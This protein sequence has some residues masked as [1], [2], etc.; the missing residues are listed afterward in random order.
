MEF[1]L[2]ELQMLA[3]SGDVTTLPLM[4]SATLTT[5]IEMSSVHARNIGGVLVGKG[6]LA[7][8][9][10]VIGGHYDH[11][12]YGSRGRGELHP[13]ADDNASGTAA[14]MILARI[15]SQQYQTTD[16]ASLRSVLFLLFD[17]EEL[18]LLG[19]AHFV[20]NPIMDLEQVNAMINLDM[21]GN[22]RNNK[23]SISGS[24]TAE[25]FETLVPQLVIASGLDASLTRGGTGPSDHANFFRKDIPILFFFTGITDEYH[26][27]EDKA[28]KTNPAGA[29][30]IIDLV[31]EFATLL[32]NDPK[33]TFTSNTAG[34]AGQTARM[35]SP[36]RLGIQPSYSALLET[37]IM[38]ASVSEGT[39]AEDAGL[40]ADDVLLAW[41]DSELVG[42]RSLM[43]MLRASKPGDVIT[44]TV[45]RDGKN[46]KVEVTL[47]A[48]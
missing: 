33:L 20:E 43:E 12:G 38:I 40:I 46:I 22:L 23:L 29:A 17:S 3:D 39:C 41:N 47:R 14:V 15:F 13:G 2:S 42:G 10:V 4:Q 26:S 1:N 37:G 18:G 45:Q 7:D 21:V 5:E 36:V 24:G 44:F 35:P 9:W 19:S 28:F 31:R 25:E 32:I 11:L 16:D 6:D 8:E 27:P 34:G 48:P 30:L